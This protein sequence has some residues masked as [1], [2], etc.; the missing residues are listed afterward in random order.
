MTVLAKG[1]CALLI[2]IVFA[3]SGCN[4]KMHDGTLT[5][6]CAVR[7]QGGGECKA[8]VQIRFGPP[9]PPKDPQSLMPSILASE[10]LPDAALHVLDL[11]SSSIPIPTSG[12]MTAQLIDSRSGKV[13]A[14]QVFAWVGTQGRIRAKDP[15]AMNDWAYRNL[16]SADTLRVDL[17]RFYS[18]FGSGPQRFSGTSI[19]EGMSI[20]G[21][22]SQFYGGSPC[23]TYPSPHTCSQN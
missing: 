16:G 14:S 17:T 23:T 9:P 22:S 21:F 1:S 10:T 12:T 8:S 13:V 4:W 7:T 19:Y 15:N 3:L 20:A 6:E 18:A 11:S 2:P 5:G